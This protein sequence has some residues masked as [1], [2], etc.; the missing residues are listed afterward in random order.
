MKMLQAGLDLQTCACYNRGG[1]PLN[2]RF[3][4][5]SGLYAEKTVRHHR[6]GGESLFLTEEAFR[7]TAFFF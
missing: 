7:P 3:R 4:T 1:G 5:Q 6:A 2:L